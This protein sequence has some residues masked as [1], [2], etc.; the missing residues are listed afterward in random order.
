MV[1][2]KQNELLY[3][4]LEPF[5]LAVLTPIVRNGFL[6]LTKV[7]SILVFRPEALKH[8]VDSFMVSQIGAILILYVLHVYQSVQDDPHE[9]T[10]TYRSLRKCV[11][12][13]TRLTGSKPET[14]LQ[15]VQK[16][17][18]RALQADENSQSQ[19]PSLDSEVLQPSSV[20]GD[21]SFASLGLIPGTTGR[22]GPTI[23]TS[24]MVYQRSGE[25]SSGAFNGALEGAV[26]P[27][28]EDSSSKTHRVSETKKDV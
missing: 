20:V 22:N 14:L 19:N 23:D 6:F 7:G 4:L 28:E 3:R 10:S 13:I 2:S 26:Y 24:N 12:E 18:F 21:Q 16:G 9:L 11:G 5:L 15:Y 1:Y 25:S 27:Y 8:P 17:R